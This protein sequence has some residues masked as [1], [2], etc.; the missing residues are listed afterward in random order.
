MMASTGI[1]NKMVC[2]QGPLIDTSIS[3]E[4]SA[5]TVTYFSLSRNSPRKSTKSLLMKRME[6]R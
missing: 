1:S 4:G 3:P 2:S 5:V 6:R